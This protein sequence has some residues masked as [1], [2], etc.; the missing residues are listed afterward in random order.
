MIIK[1]MVIG[2]WQISHATT[3]TRGPWWEMYQDE[4]LNDLAIQVTLANQDLKIA[5]ACYD[6][7][8]LL[9]DAAR[10]ELFPTIDAIAVP[11]RQEVS[12]NTANP[13]PNSVL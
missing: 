6:Q 7:L 13:S 1:N 3:L 8:K 12:Q 11:S 2:L 9:A 4:V 10:S 5:V